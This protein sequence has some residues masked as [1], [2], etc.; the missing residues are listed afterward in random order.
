MPGVTKRTGVLGVTMFGKESDLEEHITN[1]GYKAS[2]AKQ[3]GGKAN[4]D[5]RKKD[6]K[7]GKS[8]CV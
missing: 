2:V 3:A 7:L 6:I 4:R 1:H 8:G 5:V